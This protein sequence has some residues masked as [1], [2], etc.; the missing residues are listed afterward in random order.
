MGAP[1][2][3]KDAAHPLL[4]RAAAEVGCRAWVVGG[5][6]RDH[7]LG[8]PHPDLDVVVEGGAGLRLA[9]RFAELA[10]APRPVVFERFG[11]A[12]VRWDERLVEF[13]S[14]RAESYRPDSRKPDVRPAELLEDLR[15]RD[16]TVNTLVMD[17]EGRVQ[18]PLGS[19]RRDLEA[20]VLRTPDD[21]LRT[22]SDDPLRMLR[23]VRLAAQL[24]FRLDPGLAPAMRELRDRLQPPVLSVERTAEEL[25][26][27]LV[28]E[29]PRLALELMEEGGLLEVV[30][31]EVAACRGVPQTG[32]HTHD[33]Y[34]HT[35]RAVELSPPELVVRL[36]ALFHDVGKPGTAAP[37]GSF[38]GHDKLGAGLATARLQA[39]RFSHAEVERVARLVRLHLRPV[40]YQAD[41]KDGAVRRLARD[42]GDLLWPLLALA[43]ADVGASAYP[44]P[45]KLDEL[46]AR[47]RAVLEEKP[48]RF[49]LP[50]SGR[51]I[52]RTLGIPAGPRVGEV[53]ARLLELLLEGSLEPTHEAVLD[54]LKS[55]PDL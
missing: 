47:L 25:R 45:E 33:V 13:V 35:L 49:Q 52:M 41:W 51:D 40:F 3:L 50:V 43:R 54:H 55:H 44:H 19:G 4:Q 24:G 30:L 5:Y 7:L 26:R 28:S 1:A 27:M 15:R 29:R 53:K 2:P 9:E 8:R 11:T 10:G 20:R 16:F 21:P 48:S 18:D 12:Q 32:W 14:A 39:L 37:D 23:A 38:L 42:A 34:G 22:F 31:P 36:A 46:E 6:V 17:F